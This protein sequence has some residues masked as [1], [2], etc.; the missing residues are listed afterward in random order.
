MGRPLYIW[1]IGE[2]DLAQ[3][4]T[5]THLLEGYLFRLDWGPAGPGPGNYEF[6]VHWA[7]KN[8]KAVAGLC[9]ALAFQEQLGDPS[10]IHVK[11]NPQDDFK[12]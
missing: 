4:W 3:Y 10:P 9:R 7:D 5:S 6:L 8:N 12:K 2:K 1:R 11:I